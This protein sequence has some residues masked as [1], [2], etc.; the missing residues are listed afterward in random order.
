MTTTMGRGTMGGPHLE[1]TGARAARR[2]LEN[3]RTARA[4]QI[5][6]IEKTS[7]YAADELMLALL[8]T[9][10]TTL[11]EI[12]AALRR[13]DAGTYGMCQGCAAPIPARRLGILPQTR[14]C[15]P[16]QRRDGGW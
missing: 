3:E 6:A 9:T 2:R 1:R 16:C 4:G 11:E 8:N 14:F 12:D 7:R 15:A 5:A 13:V 10:R